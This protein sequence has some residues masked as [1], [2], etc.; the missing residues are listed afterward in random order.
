MYIYINNFVTF[1]LKFLHLELAYTM[2]ATEKCDVYSFGVI[3]AEVIM[4]KHPGEVITSFPTFCDDS[5][6]VSTVGDSRIPPPSSSQV[7]KQVKSVLLISKACLNSNPFERPTM[8]QVSDLLS[9]EDQLCV[10]I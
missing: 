8:R 7:E 1:D 2:M 6:S 3:A 4:G 9:L 10:D 5:V